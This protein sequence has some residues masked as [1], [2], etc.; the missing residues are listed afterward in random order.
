MEH[1]RHW[2]ELCTRDFPLGDVESS[3]AL[4]PLAAVEQHGPHLPLATD[5]LIAEALVAEAVSRHEGPAT[6][7]VLPPMAV[8]D[9][10]EHTAFP[11]TLSGRSHDLLSLWGD[12]CAGVCRAGIR[13]LVLLNTHGGNQPL[14]DLLAVRLRAEQGMLVAR[15]SYGRLGMPSGLFQADELAHGLHGGEVETSLMLALRPELVRRHALEDFGGLPA[16]RAAAG[17]LLGVE[18][19]VGMGWMSQDLHPAG[20]CGNAAA[21]DPRRGAALLAHLGEA[22]AGLV[23]E[24]AATPLSVLAAGPLDG[25]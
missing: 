23:T 13:K 20:V 6:L 12:V 15:A 8:G 18:R 1:V 5:L 24:M 2:N 7:V 9:S 14:V 10:L 17:G 16:E 25:A 21:A 11:G 19:P 3:V 4:L 22:L